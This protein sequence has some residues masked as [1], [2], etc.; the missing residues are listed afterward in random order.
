[1][2]PNSSGLVAWIA[3][4]LPETKSYVEPFCGMLGVLLSRAKSKVEIINDTN[5]NLINWWYVVRDKSDLLIDKLMYTPY[6]D[7]QFERIRES[8]WDKFDDVERA[9]AYTIILHQGFGG[10]TEV[11]RTYFGYR[12]H[13]NRPHVSNESLVNRIEALRGRLIDVRIYNMCAIKLLDKLK[14]DS[15]VLVYCDPPY[16]TASTDHYGDRG[17][18]DIASLTDILLEQQG[19]V[20]ISGYE[21]EW[22][23]LGWRVEKRQRKLSL[24]SN[25]TK[26][27]ECV[28]LNFEQQRMLG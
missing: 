1:M 21:G 18:L 22:D 9:W 26:K 24:D 11:D 17:E 28:W 19:H 8:D 5:S 14:N 23:H 13:S 12:Y 10:I 25:S 4:L 16:H 7:E 20:A 3:S 27:T 15:D 2:G 6:S